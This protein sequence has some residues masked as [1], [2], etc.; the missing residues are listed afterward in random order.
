MKNK[1]GEFHIR[2]IMRHS[3]R[4]RCRTTCFRRRRTAICRR[5]LED[6]LIFYRLSDTNA[7]TA[8]RKISKKSQKYMIFTT[9][10][11]GKYN[12]SP[13]SAAN[14]VIGKKGI[15]DTRFRRERLR[16]KI[17]S[18]P[19]NC[20][21]PSPGTGTPIGQSGKPRKSPRASP[22]LFISPTIRRRERR[23][24]RTP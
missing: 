9:N 20:G 14:H 18:V 13:V 4:S 12:F 15:L 10:G 22:P 7:S 11:V 3:R 23:S 17:G 19:G 6:T 24:L 8:E 5:L 16:Q 1:H 2:F 21:R